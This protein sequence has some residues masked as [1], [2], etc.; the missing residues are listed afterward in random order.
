MNI[1]VTGID[2]FVG[3]H[4]TEALIDI[5]EAKV[6]GIIRDSVPSSLV[7][8]LKSKIEFIKCDITDAVGFFKAIESSK[9]EKIFHLAGQAF[10][11]QSIQ[12]PLGTFRVNINGGI[13][14]LEAV[15][16]QNL[17][18]SILIVSSGEV[19]GNVSI[20]WLPIDE[21]CPLNPGNPYAASKASIDL[22]GQQYR[23]NFGMD[24]VVARPFNHLGPRQSELFV[25]SAF[26]KQVAEIKLG[27]REPKIFVGNLEPKRDFTDVRDVV[28]AYIRLLRQP[29]SF[30]VFNICSG[31]PVRIKEILDMLCELGGVQVEIMTDP[32]RQRDNDAM[33]ITGS[34]DRLRDATRWKPKIA[35]KDTLRDLLD[36]WEERIKKAA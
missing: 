17:R 9:P 23:Q 10:V 33:N 15:R 7:E 28:D 35:L 1:L 29:Q 11:P 13:N 6:F 18:C 8:H 32:D 36:Y 27:K 20:D 25:G 2:G 24:V 34:A 12:D 16:K 26:A 21:L 14:L 31:K 4:L 3:S 5:P 22:I 30:G 19:Y